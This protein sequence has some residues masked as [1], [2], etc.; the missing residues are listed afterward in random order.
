MAKTIKIMC[1][2]ELEI[3]FHK[4]KDL[5]LMND[6]KSLKKTDDSKIKKLAKSISE[7]GIV[8]NLQ[9]WKN[10]K[11]IYCFD[12]HHRKLAFELLESESWVIPLLPA[13]RSLAKTK[14]EAKR[15]LI[16]KESS[17]SWIDT[18]VITDFL[19]EIDFNLEDAESVI[20]IPD[21]DFMP[22]KK[23]KKNIDEKYTDENCELPIVP[24]FFENHQCFIIVTHNKIDE[25]FIRETLNLS[26]NRISKSGDKKIRKSNVIEVE[27]LRQLWKDK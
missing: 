3:D 27:E 4:L 18:D 24:E 8:N 23:R 19:S 25:N 13:T 20:E 21:F 6:G 26:G 11:D 12:A 17:N 5:Q 2:G 22:S 15:L 9:I 1:T 14:K 16:L 10:G 7:H